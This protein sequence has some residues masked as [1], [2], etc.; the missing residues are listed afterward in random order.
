M[1]NGW[2]LGK[3]YPVHGS[4]GKESACNAGDWDSILGSGRSP[5]EGNGNP[6]QYSCL[7]NST[8]R[9]AWWVTDHGVTK[10]VTWVSDWHFH[11]L[12]SH[13]IFETHSIVHLR[14]ALTWASWVFSYC[15]HWQAPP[16]SSGS[17]H[18]PAHMKSMGSKQVC[19]AFSICPMPRFQSVWQVSDRFVTLSNFLFHW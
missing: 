18:L 3:L 9:G 6:L 17:L 13:A 4:D 2:F 8:D 11:F 1:S 7:E 15:H 12:T 16:I 19:G 10:T 5:G 14:F